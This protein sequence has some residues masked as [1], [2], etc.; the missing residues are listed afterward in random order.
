MR[1]GLAESLPCP[2]CGKRALPLDVVDFNKSC[3][4][5]RGKYLPLSGIPVYYY[6]CEEC[7]FCFAPEFQ[8]WS[9]QDFAERIYNADYAAVDPDY[10][11][12]R[13][14]NNAALIDKLFGKSREEIRHLDYGGGAGLLS[15]ALS[16]TGWRSASYDPFVDPAGAGRLGTFD[17]ITAF[18]VFEHVPDIHGLLRELGGLMSDNSL[19]LLSTLLSDGEIAKDKR[20]TWWYA[21]PRNGHISLFSQKSLAIALARIGLKFGSFARGLHVAF[22]SLPKWASHLMKGG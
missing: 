5:P 1:P 8:R 17:L 13:P 7:G 2:V 18:E 4:E 12:T 3:E 16:E 19:V 15:R 14:K 11:G 22:R 21:S 6:L 9:H 20:L 10:S